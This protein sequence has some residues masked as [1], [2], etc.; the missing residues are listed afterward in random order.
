MVDRSNKPSAI[1]LAAGGPQPTV[2]DEGGKVTAKLPTGESVDVM[3]YGATVTS[4]KNANGHENLFLSTAAKL[5]GSKA[6]RGGIPLVFPVFGP[7]P[8]DHATSSLPQHGFA[9]IS[10]WEYLGKSTSESALVS[11]TGD[12]AVR[13]DFGLTPANISPEMRKAWPYKFALQ[14][15]VTLGRDGLQTALEVRNPGTEKWDFQMLTHTYFA[16]PVRLML[17]NNQ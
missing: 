13:L 5:D 1:S 11:K 7:P 15:S 12:S 6:I 14:Y 4:W 17:H 10:H 16:T 3:L 9:R 8:K 2:T